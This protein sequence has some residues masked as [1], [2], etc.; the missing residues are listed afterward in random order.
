MV[1]IRKC[2]TRAVRLCIDYRKLNK[3]TQADPFQMPLIQ[4]LL[5]NVAGATWLTR[6]DMNKGLYQVFLDRDSENKTVLFYMGKISIQ[7]NAF[8][9]MNAP[10]TFQRCMNETFSKHSEYS[11]TYMD[12]VLV[13]SS[14]WEEHL[15]HL[16]PSPSPRKFRGYWLPLK[17][18]D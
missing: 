1:P 11:S 5:D 14:S 9:L 16:S 15:V 17:R 12:D 6:L 4:E 13:N 10:A 7:E 3:A 2:S 8:G 18:Q